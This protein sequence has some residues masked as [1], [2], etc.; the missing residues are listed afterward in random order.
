V[1]S[2]LLVYLDTA[3]KSLFLKR[4]REQLPASNRPTH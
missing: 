3:K 2:G 4:W 1:G